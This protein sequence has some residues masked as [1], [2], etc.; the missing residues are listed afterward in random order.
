MSF[1]VTGVRGGSAEKT[2]LT[3]ALEEAGGTI[4][5][6]DTL[7]GVAAPAGSASSSGASDQLK[8]KLLQGSVVLISDTHKDGEV[9]AT[10]SLLFG[11]AFGLQPLR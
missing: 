10:P 4:V 2:K 8:A 9:K 5:A 11:I 6:D 7:E 1:L 3:E